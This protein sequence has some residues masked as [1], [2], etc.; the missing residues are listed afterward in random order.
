MEVAGIPQEYVRNQVLLTKTKGL[1]S[2]LTKS[3]FYIIP[4]AYN[5]GSVQYGSQ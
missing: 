5:D 3:D 1:R 4:Q 2:W